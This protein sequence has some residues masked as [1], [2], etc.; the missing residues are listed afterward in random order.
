MCHNQSF[1]PMGLVRS[2]TFY[3][4]LT[5]LCGF[6]GGTYSFP[7]FFVPNDGRFFQK[8]PETVQFVGIDAALF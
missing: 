3:P 6:A 5:P 4:R 7:S 8:L 2:F 1:A